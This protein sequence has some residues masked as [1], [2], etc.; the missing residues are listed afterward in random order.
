MDRGIVMMQCRTCGGVY[1]QVGADGLTYYHACP[2][3]SIAELRDAL[4]KKTLTLSPQQQQRLDAATQL[5]AQTPLPADSPSRVES[6]LASLTVER[7]NK[8]DENVV[9][10]AN[11]GDKATMK[12]PG[13]GVTKL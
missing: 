8:R 3:L 12:A 11:P 6:F 2:P 7:P 9:P 4:A 13:A 10:P 1:D 5:D